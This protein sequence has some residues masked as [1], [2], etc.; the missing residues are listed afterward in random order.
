[1]AEGLFD[2]FSRA[3]GQ[4]RRAALEGL[5][6]QFIPPELRPQL[7]LLAEA[8]PT[9]AAE[10]AG[11]S[12]GRMVQPGLS[13][14][15]RMAAAGDTL[16]NMAGV[17]APV[18]A[19]RAVGMAPVQAVEEALLGAS[20][21]PQMAAVRDYL[22][23]DFGGVSVPR[24]NKELLDPLGYQKTKMQD[25]LANTQLDLVD[26]G[27]NLPRTAAS[28]EDMENKLIL[29]LYGDRS[30]AGMLL[31]GID[32][33]RF[34]T[35]VFTEGGVDFKRGPAAQADRAVW[36]SNNNIITRIA[37]EAQKARE[38]YDES[39]IFGVT[40]SMAPD[41]N[42]FATFTGETMAE[43]VKGAPIKAAD[44]ANFDEV[45][46]AIDPNFVGVNSPMLRDWVKNTTSPNRK[47]FIRLMDSAPMQAAGFP[48][49]AQARYGVT[50]IT[51]RDLPAGMFGL[52]VS[53]LDDVSPILSN[54]PRGNMPAASVPHS[55]YNT[56]ITGEYVGSLPPV[57]QSLLF[58]SVYDPMEGGVTKSGQ[59]FN[60][61][62]KTHAI[63]TIMPV[64]RVTPQKLEGILNYLARQER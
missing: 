11:Q 18:A 25:Y 56:Q 19:G 4:E 3:R 53:R 45:M 10:L 17:L 41:A 5:L 31:R 57:P 22:V 12:A 26:T 54:T 50:D 20:A 15:E 8:T 24:V 2:F 30:S 39:D 42:D 60:E 7:G 21:S 13:G 35:P 16:S 38:A 27:V 51:Q 23:D 49:P 62:H 52:G 46:R 63:K 64:E 37:N 28:W 48:S 6:T 43:M 1:M 29:P 32:D 61:A 14:W 58:R 34:D 59:P 47:S 44:A 55:T 33:T 9:R 40:G 36:A